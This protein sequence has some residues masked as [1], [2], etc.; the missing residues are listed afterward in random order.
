VTI[1]AQV[2]GAHGVLSDT[3]TITLPDSRPSPTPTTTG[4]PTLT[5]TSPPTATF[6]LFP[7]G[8]ATFTPTI[9]P[10]ATATVPVG[11]LKFIS[12]VPST[13]GVRSSGLPEQSVVTFQATDTTGKP[14]AGATVSFVLTG[15]GTELVNPLVAITDANGFVSTTVTSGTRATTIRVTAQ[16]DSNGD[17]VPDIFMQS[18]VVSILG[19]PPAFN[20]FS[21]GSFK[22]NIAGRVTFGLTDQISAFVD[23]RFGNAVPP[24]TSVSFVTNAASVVDPTTTGTNGVATATLLSEGIVTPSGVVT[25]LAFTRGEESFLDNNG[26]GRFD[27]L[28]TMNPPCPGLPGGDTILTDDTPEPFIDFRPL[29][30]SLALPLGLPDDSACTV[31]AP[32]PLC[33]NRFDVNKPFELFVDNPPPDGM[34]DA[35]GTT[36]YWDNNIFV[37]SATTVTFSGPT[38][39]PVLAS[40]SPGPCSGFTL[41]PGD[42][43]SF[44]IN[45]HDDLVNPLVGGST[46]VITSTGGTISGGNISLP[47]G[48]SFNQ[49]VDNLTRFT[50]SLSVDQTVTKTTNAAISVTITSPNGNVTAALTNGI[51]AVP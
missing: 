3:K 17:G 50:F 19:A 28:G 8:Q 16:A 32:S 14:I 10:T 43:K 15:S 27:C 13:I 12:A 30:P 37:W 47:D 33:N 11:S 7:T 48:E 1:Q 2:A 40:C 38:Q 18:Q 23:D 22:K 49:L 21:V 35:Q 5:P 34:W 4:T 25:I 44:T 36:G 29:P 26:N 45:V 9:G 31:P 39:T 46:I 51:I 24:S 42:S 20:H 6:T 41:H